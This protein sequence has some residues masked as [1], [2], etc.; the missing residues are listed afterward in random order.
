MYRFYVK[1]LINRIFFKE[2][3]MATFHE[4]K[5][6]SWEVVWISLWRKGIENHSLILVPVRERQPVRLCLSVLISQ[7][8]SS[9]FLS[10]QPEPASQ[11]PFSEQG[12][13]WTVESVPSSVIDALV[14]TYQ[15]FGSQVPVLGGTLSGLQDTTCT[16]TPATPNLVSTTLQASLHHASKQKR[17]AVP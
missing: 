7:P 8:F 2:V 17:W 12:G 3:R 11:K 9:V 13:R 16:A 5:L 4:E 15:S 10:Q 14:V 6:N 1:I